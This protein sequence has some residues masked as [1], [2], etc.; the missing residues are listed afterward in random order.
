MYDWR[1]IAKV[2]TANVRVV[3]SNAQVLVLSA[4]LDLLIIA[5]NL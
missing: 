4:I 3:Q 1:A 2:P 5:I